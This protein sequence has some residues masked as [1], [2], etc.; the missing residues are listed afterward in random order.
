MLPL[1]DPAS[2]PLLYHLNSEPWLN[3][4]AYSEPSPDRQSE[5]VSAGLE[6][7]PSVEARSELEKVILSRRSWRQFDAART[8]D[9]ATIGQILRFAYGVSCWPTPR[10]SLL[11]PVPSAG[12]LYPLH[13]LVSIQRVTGLQDGLYQYR[14][15]AH[16]L[17]RC[18]DL[19]PNRLGPVIVEQ[20]FAEAAN[21]ALFLV[22]DLGRTIGKYGARGYRY[23]LLEAGHAAQNVCL[24][25]SEQLLATL[26]VGGFFDARLR[27]ALGLTGGLT[28]PL[29][30]VIIG[31][32]RQDRA[33]P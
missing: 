2:L 4:A 23:V 10:V 30:G 6:P 21:V 22:G 12:S 16:A 25:A 20:R 26:C 27:T 29:Y 31:W 11:R 1:N 32:P 18:G 24:V 19:S 7:L 5:P 9:P 13:L 28:W 14:P 33:S 15:L 8:L 3:A 17:S